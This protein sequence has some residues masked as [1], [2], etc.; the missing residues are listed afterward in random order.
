MVENPTNLEAAEV[1]RE[2]QAGL[3]AE[4]VLTAFACEGCDRFT[5]AGVLPDER[6]VDVLSGKPI[7]D[8]GSLTLVGDA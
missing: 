2:G 6:V 4:A 5:N 1:G 3:G 7:P 8:H